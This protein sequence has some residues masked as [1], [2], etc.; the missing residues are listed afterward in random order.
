[1]LSIF[2]TAQLAV[3][4]VDEHEV[5]ILTAIEIDDS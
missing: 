2:A 1:V 5:A 3:E 4:R